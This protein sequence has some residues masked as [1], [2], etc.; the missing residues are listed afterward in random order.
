MGKKV[1]V[2]MERW[3]DCGREGVMENGLCPRCAA[4]KLLKTF[5]FADT[6]P[7]TRMLEVPLNAHELEEYGK[8]L[9]SIIIDK[10]KLEAE[11]AVISKRI[12]PLVERLEM[13]APVID[14]GLEERT[15][16]CTWYYDW[17]ANERILVRNDCSEVVEFD[18]IPDY[19]RQQ[20]LDV[21]TQT[22]PKGKK[23]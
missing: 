8:Q 6:L 17:D 4:S 19:M 5:E 3:C 2:E 23:K 13:L 1:T 9:A 20:R 14:S 18:T 16:D 12:K 21:T 7:E 11:K 22:R 10:G 15:V